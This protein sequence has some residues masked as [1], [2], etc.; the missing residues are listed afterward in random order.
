MNVFI[1]DGGLSR[2]FKGQEMGNEKRPFLLR[3]AL[4]GYRMTPRDDEFLM[5]LEIGGEHIEP[6]LHHQPIGL[7]HLTIY[8]PERHLSIHEQM[9]FLEML[10]SHP[11]AQS[12]ALKQVDLITQSPLICKSTHQGEMV[13]VNTTGSRGLTTGELGRIKSGEPAAEVIA[14]ALAEQEE[15]V[16]QGKD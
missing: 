5:L 14:Q 9:F 4:A 2:W 1:D 3:V 7:G 8:F 11:E 12:G 16:K 15:W 13:M 6:I 10:S